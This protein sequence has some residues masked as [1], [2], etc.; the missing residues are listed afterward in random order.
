MDSKQKV[1]AWLSI[2]AAA[3]AGGAGTAT[4]FFKDYT[5]IITAGSALIGALIAYFITKNKPTEK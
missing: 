5:A 1:I 3:I 2:L 4:A